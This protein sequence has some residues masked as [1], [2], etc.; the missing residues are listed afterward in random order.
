MHNFISL[1]PVFHYPLPSNSLC[2]KHN[3]KCLSLCNTKHSLDTFWFLLQ[4]CRYL[5]AAIESGDVNTVKILLKSAKESCITDD[6]VHYTP[7]MFAAYKGRVDLVRLFLESGAS[8][9]ITNEKLWTPLHV[10]A[11]HGQLE[12]CRLF[13]DWGAQVNPVSKR[14]GNI[15][16]H[17]A[18]RRGH[19]SVVKLLVERGANIRLRNRDGL[20]AGDVARIKGYGFVAD[21][22]KKQFSG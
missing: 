4:A 5:F 16:L 7:L 18:A 3:N 12:V 6:E 11:Y 1:T 9:E 20:T 15:P 10:A 14:K 8:V 19:L 22:L 17:S 13:L 2:Q 21:W